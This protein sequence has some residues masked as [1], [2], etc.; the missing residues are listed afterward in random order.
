MFLVSIYLHTYVVI[1]LLPRISFKIS[2]ATEEF[3]ETQD[4]LICDLLFTFPL[5]YPDEAPLLEIENENFEDDLVKEKLIDAVKAMIE[6]NLGAEMIFTLVAGAQ[7]LLNQL[8]D[9]IKNER[10]QKKLKREQEIE[11]AERK[12][13]EGTRVSWNPQLRSS[14]NQNTFI[15]L[16]SQ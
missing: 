10:E 14:S 7:E 8:F 16:R 13:F 9:E 15:Y 11:E 12:R 2:I 4:G 5:Q 1:E 6:E 3:A